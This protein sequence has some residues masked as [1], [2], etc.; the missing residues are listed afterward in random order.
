MS[1][2]IFSISFKTCIASTSDLIRSLLSM[3]NLARNPSPI[4]NRESFFS[5]VNL[6]LIFVMHSRILI[7]RSP[8]INLTNSILFSFL[9]FKVCSTSSVNSL[10]LANNLFGFVTDLA[11]LSAV[12]AILLLLFSAAAAAGA[13]GGV[14]AAVNGVTLGGNKSGLPESGLAAAAADLISGAD[15][16]RLV[17]DV[18][19]AARGVVSGT[20]L[21]ATDSG[22]DRPAN[23]AVSAAA[24]CDCSA[25]LAAAAAAAWVTA[26]TAAASGNLFEDTGSPLFVTVAAP[27]IFA[28][29]NTAIIA[30]FAAFPPP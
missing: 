7:P 8:A 15:L 10:R 30:L 22:L 5:S 21:D 16:G 6:S 12:A 2:I 28:A 14:L 1:F 26:A 27:D 3:P 29:V 20:T 11:S 9:A 13:A 18:E 17:S 25:G 19:V 24:A 23:A 4:R